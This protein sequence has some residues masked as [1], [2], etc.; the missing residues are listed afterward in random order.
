MQKND[1]FWLIAKKAGCTMAELEQ[2]NGKS[3]ND[4]IYPG[5]VLKVPQK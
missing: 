2:L 1:S 5:E 4:M 3:G